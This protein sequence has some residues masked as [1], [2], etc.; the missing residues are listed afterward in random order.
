MGR[1]VFRVPIA[2]SGD[3][4]GEAGLAALDFGLVLV[5]PAVCNNKWLWLLSLSNTPFR[6]VGGRCE[7]ST[8]AGPG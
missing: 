5:V 3:E 6:H 8:P 2:E 1:S 7:S 4:K